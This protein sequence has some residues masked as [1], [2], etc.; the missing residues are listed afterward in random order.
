MG[1]GSGPRR[2]ILRC[3]TSAA[4]SV[5]ASLE[6]SRSLRSAHR[7]RRRRMSFAMPLTTSAIATLVNA[8]RANPSITILLFHVRER[9]RVSLS[10]SLKTRGDTRVYVVNLFWSRARQF[11]VGR[12]ASLCNTVRLSR[13]FSAQLKVSNCDICRVWKGKARKRIVASI[14]TW[15][16]VL[17]PNFFRLFEKKREIII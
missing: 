9:Y 15:F 4:V 8:R 1:T 3:H 11:V 13:K 6:D 2:R 17:E 14:R 10:G 7:S 12:R 16:A 5:K